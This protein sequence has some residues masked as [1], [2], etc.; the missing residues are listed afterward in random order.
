MKEIS[1][2]KYAEWNAIEELVM[3]YKKQFEDGST[4]EE[5]RESRAAANKLIER[6]NPLFKKYVLLFKTC[7]I[8]FTDS[9]VKTFIR[10]FIADPRLHRALKRTRSKTEFRGEIYK[11]F[12]F[13]CETYGQLSEDD[14]LID[15][16][17]LL[18]VLAKRY[19]A[20]GKNFCAYVHN[21]FRYEVS[22]H[23]KKFIK[24]PINIG[25]KNMSYADESNGLNDAGLENSYEDNYYE[26]ETGIPNATWISG[27]TC[28]DVFNTLSN[29]ERKIIVMYY[30]EEKND[31]QISKALGLHINTINQKRRKAISIIANECDIDIS[32]VRRN[33][34]SGKT[35]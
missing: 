34:H 15:L 20:M 17:M 28:S 13:V 10:T 29:I 27:E 4:E 5:K 22:R 8:D 19:K 25:Y 21:C 1:T 26:S 6:F 12:A 30:A 14:I 9:D 23:V 7:Q 18:L 16:Q 11:K 32:E 31:K 33:R 35:L 3:I 2:E 24:N